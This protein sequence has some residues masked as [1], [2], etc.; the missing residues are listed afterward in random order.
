[1][2]Y[3]NR[4]R[5]C[6]RVLFV[7]G[8][9]IFSCTFTTWTTVLRVLTLAGTTTASPS[10]LRL[11]YPGPRGIDSGFRRVSRI[12]YSGWVAALKTVLGGRCNGP[13]ASLRRFWMILKPPKYFPDAVSGV[14]LKSVSTVSCIIYRLKCCFEMGLSGH[15][16]GP[17][18]TLQRFRCVLRRPMYFSETVSSVNLR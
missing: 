7:S 10:S 16:N 2:L 17:F 9:G 15:Y 5:L 6:W 8:L 1:M 11:Q 18:G 3:S 12:S 13:S 4:V 14:H